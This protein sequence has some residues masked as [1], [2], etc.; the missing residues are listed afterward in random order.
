M[1]EI[2]EIKKSEISKKASIH[3]HITGLGLDEN[4]KPKF[5]AE[6]L[7]G[8]LEAREAAGIVVELVKQGKMAGRGILF[9][10]PPG[11]GK[12]ALA[13]AIARE[14]GEDT[15][16]TI[17]NAA[18]IYSTELKKTEI[19]TQVLRK[20]IGI[21]IKQ[22]RLVYEGV[23]KD[24]K[25]R[26]V[27]SKLNPYMAM[28]KEAEITLATKDDQ[29]TLRVGDVVA[30]RLYKLG[31]RKGDVIWI[32]AETGDI[33]R[34]GKVKEFEGVKSY[35]IEAKRIVEIPTGPVK[36]EKEITTVVTL[37]DLDLNLAAQQLA[38]TSIFALF[39]EREISQ[40]VRKEVDKI[41]RDMLNKGQAELVPGVLFIDDAHMLDIEAFSFLTRAMESEFSPLIILATNRGIT[42]IRGTDIDSPHGIP[43]DMLDRLLII[44]TRPYTSEEIKQIIQIRADEIDVEL[45]SSAIEELTKI[46]SEYSLRYAVQLIEPAKIIAQRKNRSVV[47][48]ED[49]REAQNLFADIKR[50]IKY[51]KEYESLFLR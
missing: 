8:Q 4:G 5:K 37:H 24:I 41:V 11:T 36:K 42:K 35:D 28:P 21:R 49:I 45:D 38:I 33:V 48:A 12:T 18:E 26:I 51:V 16:F 29:T 47:K 44:P 20:S 34:L 50:S 22:K 25:T 43:L 9:V 14:L 40:D 15:P 7:V 1:V 31:I 17:L 19:L 30:E 2:T 13:I 3:S 10:G 32:D 6:G 39:T 23:V 46:G 27:R